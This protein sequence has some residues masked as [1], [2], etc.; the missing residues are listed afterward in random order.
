M[1]NVIDFILDLFRDQSHA[2]AFV[3][4]PQRAMADAGLSTVTS[5]QLASVAATAVPSLAL[6]EGDPVVGLQRAVSSH[7]GLGGFE[8]NYAPSWAPRT[9]FSPSTQLASGNSILSPTTNI[10]DDH[11][12]NVGFGDFTLGDKTSAQGPGA[13]AIGGSNHGDIVSGDGAVLGNGNSVNNGDIRTGAHSNVAVGDHNGISAGNTAAGGDV[14]TS[15]DGT[16][17][18]TSGHGTTANSEGNSTSVHGNQTA[19]DIHGTGNTSGVDNSTR[20]THTSTATTDT[21]VHDNSV[22][23]NSVHDN[24]VHD[25][26]VHDTAASYD[27]SV[28]DNTSV[29]ES[30]HLNTGMETHLGF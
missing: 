9:D 2:A 4:D 16:V 30:T 22:H 6:G 10:Q 27:S 24:S 5:A 3:A 13:V 19:T 17:I 18:Q 20:V 8:P 21:S 23:D 28:H 14:L 1:I 7:Y 29:H 25:N 15:H 12:I 26:P 11:S